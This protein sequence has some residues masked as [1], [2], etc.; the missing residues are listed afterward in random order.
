MIQESRDMMKTLEWLTEQ[1]LKTIEGLPPE[2]LDWKPGAGTNSAAAIVTHALGASRNWLVAIVARRPNPRDR[3]AEFLATGGDLQNVP[4]HAKSL[5]A[6]A[7]DILGPMTTTDLDALCVLPAAMQSE[8]EGLTARG[9]ILHVLEHLG[10]HIGHLQLTL[11][12]RRTP[13]AQEK[14]G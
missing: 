13:M 10:T 3:E 4:A 1:L 6:A 14:H 12:L 9:A 7:R 8:W 5:L 2:A 11:Q